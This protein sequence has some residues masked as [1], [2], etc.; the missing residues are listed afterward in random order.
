VTSAVEVWCPYCGEPAA[1]D[2]DTGGAARQSYVQDCPVCCQP[3]EVD[4]TRDRDG[5]WSATLRTADE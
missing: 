3:W 5:E 1:L 4:V 2:V